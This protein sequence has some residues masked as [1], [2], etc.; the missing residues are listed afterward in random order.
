MG[1][2]VADLN[3]LLEALHK[4]TEGQLPK[5]ALDA[6]SSFLMRT[7]GA[8]RSHEDVPGP[9]LS[10]ALGVATAAAKLLRRGA[11][12]KALCDGLCTGRGQNI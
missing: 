7:A 3:S 1:E 12:A 2:D 10:T 4:Q 11:A 6:A 5:G 9:V 8:S